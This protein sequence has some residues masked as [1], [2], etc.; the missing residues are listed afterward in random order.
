M[1][2]P[3]SLGADNSLRIHFLCQLLLINFNYNYKL[4]LLEI[5]PRGFVYYILFNCI[6]S[7]INRVSFERKLVRSWMWKWPFRFL[8][9][10]MTFSFPLRCASAIGLTLTL[11][12]LATQPVDTH[13]NVPVPLHGHLG[14][15]AALRDGPAPLPQGRMQHLRA[16]VHGPF[17]PEVSLKQSRRHL[18][19]LFGHFGQDPSIASDPSCSGHI[20]SASLWKWFGSFENLY[21]DR[22]VLNAAV[23]AIAS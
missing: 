9:R 6:S 10:F 7:Q 23:N 14:V 16:K 8:I 22:N 5:P 21:N 13:P 20:S 1:V 19:A 15:E 12:S 11:L 17:L 18:S 3:S 4:I 2:K